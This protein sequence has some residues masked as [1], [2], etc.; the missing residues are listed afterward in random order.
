MPKKQKRVKTIVFIDGSNIYFA[1]K[2]LAWQLDWNKV[3][4]KLNKEFDV[5]DFRYYTAVKEGDTAMRKYLTKLEKKRVN[6][7]TKPLK[8]IQMEDGGEV[9][10][11]NM[12]V[13]ITGDALL[14][15]DKFEVLVLFSGD[16]DLAYLVKLLHQF[17]KTV[18]VYSSKKTLSWEL[19]MECNE[20]RFL[21]G[22]KQ[23][24][25]KRVKLC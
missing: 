18:I 3:R 25:D 21:E 11:G 5:I 10:K 23:A 9:Y 17:K 20:Y 22:L 14:A 24:L 12:D 16:S 6:I 7:F 19:K 8:L 4:E 2:K 13:E 15:K 1:Q